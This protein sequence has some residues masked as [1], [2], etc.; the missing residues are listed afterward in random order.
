MY[1]GR[2]NIQISQLPCG[3][4]LKPIHGRPRIL[5]SRP[6]APWPPW[7]CR[8]V[9]PPLEV[10]QGSMK[11]LSR[12]FLWSKSLNKLVFLTS[13][14]SKSL[15][16]SNISLQESRGQGD[17]HCCFRSATWVVRGPAN[18]LKAMLC[19]RHRSSSCLDWTAI[20]GDQHGLQSWFMKGWHV[21]FPERSLEGSWRMLEAQYFQETEWK[22]QNDHQKEAACCSFGE[23]FQGL[24]ELDC[25]NRVMPWSIHGPWFVFVRFQARSEGDDTRK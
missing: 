10:W 22:Q 21:G 2:K 8:C 3:F 24:Y 4:S 25:F 20:F 18:T 15:K 1:V 17:S 16:G 12:R 6:T 23:S 13:R 14:T 9:P 11:V 5:Q 7:P 19:P